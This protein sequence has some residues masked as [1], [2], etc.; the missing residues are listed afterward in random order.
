[1]RIDTST[2]VV[3]MDPGSATEIVVDVVNTAQV[4]DGVS[5]RVIG[6]PQQFVRAEPQLLPLFPDATGRLTL[7]LTVPPS[8]PAGRHPLTVEVISHGA[9]LPTQYLDVDL[10]VHAQPAIRLGASPRSIRARRRGR[11][12]LE[13]TNQGN[14]TLDVSLRAAEA[15]RACTLHF[16]PDT[17]QVLAGAT[18]AVI[19]DVRGPRMIAGGEIDRVVTVEAS[20]TS[21]LLPG[22]DPSADTTLVPLTT[23]VQLRQRPLLSRGMI[24]ALILACIVAL[25]AGVFLLGLTKVFSGDPMT[26]SAPA[27]FF[28]GTPAADGSSGGQAGKDGAPAGALSKTGQVP[29]GAGGTITGTVTSTSEG[30]PV[31][32]ILV[33]A[34]RVGPDGPQVVSSSASQA[35]GTYSLVGLFPGQY[36]VSFRATGF[37]TV[38]YPSATSRDAGTLVSAAAQATT[39]GANVVITGLP[40]SISGTVDPGDTLNPVVATVT[41]RP[42]MSVGDAG[43]VATTKTNAS[44]HYTLSKL[45]APASYELTFTA[46]GYRTTTLVDTI[47]GGDQRLEPTVLLGTG[48]GQISGTVTDGKTP[49][50][51]VTVSTTVGGKSLTVLT[52]TMGQVGSFTL[53]SLPTPGT[54]VVTFAAPGYGSQ[55]RIIDLAAGQKQADLTATLTAGTGSVTGRLVDG[56]G[57]GLGGAAV[58]VGGTV[59]GGGG[60]APATTTLTSGSVGSFLINGLAAPGSYTMTFAKTGYAPVTIPVTLSGNGAPPALQVEMTT[61]LG[62]ITGTV[63]V[64]D[65]SGWKPIVGATVRITNGKDVFSTTSSGKGGALPGGGYLITGLAPGSYA[66]TASVPGY[67]QQ[68]ALVT[69]VAGH[70]AD[71]SLKLGR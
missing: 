14:I 22:A 65:G 42:L 53:G 62:G 29:A 20:P 55:T 33:E 44:G 15:D 16:A 6:L 34:V 9:K 61:R 1:M 54:Y 37:R 68:T 57:N 46:P 66:V 5:A 32:R 11:F 2:R 58:T 48:T 24:T 63:S 59:A 70:R 7:S 21:G 27:S 4:I 31:G 64:P 56:D 51:G 69:V 60:A 25:W 45:P 8:H 40:G 52:P 17:V 3:E 41:A 36:Y 18:V 67:G 10:N 35:D 39:T 49:I 13:L 50:G 47:N 43:P 12:V 19:L 71:A 30:R 38:W 28:A 23:T 26:K